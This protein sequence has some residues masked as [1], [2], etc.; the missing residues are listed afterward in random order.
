MHASAPDAKEKLEMNLS[1]WWKP[2]LSVIGIKGVPSDLATAGN[3][4]YKEL[5]FR[6]SVRTGPTQ[7]CDEL[8]A[9]MK[10][11]IMDAPA[12]I[13]YNAKVDFE[14]VDKGSGFCAP[15]LP[16]NVEQ[17]VFKSTK[18]VFEG[19]DPVFVGCGGSI[20]FMEIFSNEFPNA[21]FLL[22]GA[23]NITGNAH[24]AN[25]NLDLEYCRKFIT[26]IALTLSRL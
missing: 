23:A 20:P 9:K 2:A 19:R 8:A 21:N 11:A 12:E 10:Q 16:A 25:E 6:C 5:T 3:V 22:T 1:Q 15:D 26:T 4:V 24:C 14:V 18:E 7:D 17:A 13:T